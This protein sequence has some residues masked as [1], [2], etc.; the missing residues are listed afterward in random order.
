MLG[1]YE[2]L[3]EGYHAKAYPIL[4]AV[5]EVGDEEVPELPSVLPEELLRLREGEGI[6]DRPGVDHL[7]PA[8][9]ML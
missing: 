8:S 5:L 3:H 1:I 6:T 2:V 7:H 4:L 9:K